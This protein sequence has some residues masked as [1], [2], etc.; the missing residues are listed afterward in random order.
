M[1]MPEIVNL[2]IANS[3][4]NWTM[5]RFPDRFIP[6]SKSTENCSVENKWSVSLKLFATL[7][8]CDRSRLI[9]IYGQSNYQKFDLQTFRYFLSNSLGKSSESRAVIKLF[10]DMQFSD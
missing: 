7:I 1:H 4:C 5:D 10:P 8:V 3:F 6:V 9:V 2:I